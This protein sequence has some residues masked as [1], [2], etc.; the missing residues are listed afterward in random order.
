MSSGAGGNQGEPAQTPTG[1]VIV[2][3]YR[4]RRGA[5]R[6]WM[7]QAGTTLRHKTSPSPRGRRET[8]RRVLARWRAA[9][10]DVP[11]DLTDEHP[12]LSGPDRIVLEALSGPTLHER[13][14]R[15]P[16]AERDAWLTRFAAGW[17]RRHE[18]VVRTGD[19]T[20]LQEHGSFH[21]V[22]L[23]GPRLVTIDHEQVYTRGADIQALLLKEVLGYVRSIERMGAG[24]LLADDLR[25]LLGAY[26][27]PARLVHACELG[28]APG[29]MRQTLQTLEGS[30]RTRR[31]QRLTEL[32]RDLAQ[33]ELTRRS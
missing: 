3:V 2:K 16:R 24:R 23:H 9:G 33:A 18:H 10:F 15:R 22:L 1:P 28:L 14:R 4:T 11:R 31:K 25:A 19:P 26:D 5:L 6:E 30:K 21:H 29:P 27:D 13:L 7:R 17:S 8:E 20:F 12:E 32:V